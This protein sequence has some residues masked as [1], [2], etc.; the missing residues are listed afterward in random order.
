[1]RGPTGSMCVAG[2]GQGEPC[3]ESGL[4]LA[5]ERCSNT[6]RKEGGVQ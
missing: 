1:M 2:A 5:D 6:E 3:A 4:D